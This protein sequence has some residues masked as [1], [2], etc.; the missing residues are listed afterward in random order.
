MY[1]E[2]GPQIKRRKF[3]GLG[4]LSPGV[5]LR[6]QIGITR[7][8]FEREVC[9][10]VTPNLEVVFLKPPCV[11]SGIVVDIERDSLSIERGELKH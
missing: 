9:V 10:G 8:I 3:R 2:G 6:K 7:N 4:L 1:R 5:G 11:K